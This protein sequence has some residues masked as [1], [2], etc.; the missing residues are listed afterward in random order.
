[1]DAHDQY[2][3]VIRAI[4][5]ADAA[6]LRKSTRGPPQKIMFKFL[7]AWLL[8]TVNLASLWINPGHHMADGAVLA[9]RVDPLKNQ[10]QGVAVDA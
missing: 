1:M 4:E 5:Y 2:F 8:E 7:G 3:L 6:T 9:G 10:Q